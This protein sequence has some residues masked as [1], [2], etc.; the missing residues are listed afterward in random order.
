MVFPTP[1][2][3][4]PTP[5]PCCSLID[6][7]GRGADLGDHVLVVHL[8]EDVTDVDGALLAVSVS[9]DVAAGHGIDIFLLPLHSVKREANGFRR[10]KG[11]PCDV[12]IVAGIQGVLILAAKV[13]RDARV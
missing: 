5:Y 8:F 9:V 3:L 1:Y 2:P 4:S 6:L 10:S 13:D 12:Q 11:V 7:I